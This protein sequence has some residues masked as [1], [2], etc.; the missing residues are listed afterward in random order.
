M[1]MIELSES[2]RLR[3]MPPP[4]FSAAFATPSL[5]WACKKRLRCLHPDAAAA[6]G[7]R[8]SS[9]DDDCTTTTTNNEVRRRHRRLPRE[10]LAVPARRLPASHWCSHL[11]CTQERGTKLLDG[12]GGG[13]RSLRSGF[14]NGG[15]KGKKNRR[16]VF[17]GAWMPNRISAARYRVPEPSDPRKVSTGDGS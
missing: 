13:G 5:R 3:A 8:F 14:R 10:E 2:E 4:N 17:P 12:H 16:A 7:R 1:V 15:E 9:F 6:G 11:I